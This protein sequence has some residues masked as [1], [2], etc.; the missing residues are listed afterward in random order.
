M[1][2]DLILI[3]NQNKGFSVTL[4]EAKGSLPP[5]LNLVNIYDNWKSSLKK[6]EKFKTERQ[7]TVLRNSKVSPRKRMRERRNDYNQK[8]RKTKEAYGEAEEKLINE[9]NNWLRAESF[10]PIVEEL[11]K[12]SEDTQKILQIRLITSDLEITKLPWHNWSWI[13]ERQNRVSIVFRPPLEKY[14]YP[15]LIANYQVKAL[16]VLGN[17][18]DS[19]EEK[20]YNDS[21]INILNNYFKNVDVHYI[22]NPSTPKIYEKLKQKYDIIYIGFHSETK[23]NK[24]QFQINQTD[25][26]SIDNL[27]CLLEKQNNVKLLILN[28]CDGSGAS[29]LFQYNNKFKIGNLIYHRNFLHHKS[30][31]IFLKQLLIS[32]VQQNKSLDIAVQDAI[33]YLDNNNTTDNLNPIKQECP[34]ANLTP[35]YIQLSQKSQY[36]KNW[37]SPFPSFP[38]SRLITV[39]SLLV[40][41]FVMGIK[42]LGFFEPLGLWAFDQLMR[43]KPNEEPDKRILVVQA[44][45]DD[46]KNQKIKPESKDTLLGERRQPSLSDDTLKQLLEKLNKYEPTAIGLDIDRDFYATSELKTELQKDHVFGVCKKTFLSGSGTKP[47]PEINNIGFVDAIEDNDKTL[48]RHILTSSPENSDCPVNANLSF[49]LGLYYLYKQEPKLY[50]LY[51][52]KQDEIRNKNKNAC[53][54]T[55]GKAELK[56]LNFIS[57]TTNNP[58]FITRLFQN[59]QGSY[60]NEDLRGCQ[61]MLNYRI[62]DSSIK[63]IAE[64]VTLGQVLNDEISEEKIKYSLILVG[65]VD[66]PKESNDYWRTPYSREEIAG[67]FIQAQMLSQILSAALDGRS[68]INPLLF[69]QDL[70]V[71]FACSFISSLTVY[72][73]TDRLGKPKTFLVICGNGFLICV[74]SFCLLL[75]LGIWLPLIPSV[76]VII[77]APITIWIGEIDFKR[78]EKRLNKLSI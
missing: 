59:N 30:S 69:W 17:L 72:L 58:S 62:V 60:H 31:E 3:S 50:E 33:N 37:F 63:N 24:F 14:P 2:I 70:I 43:L 64:T 52:N 49:L 54:F 8:L 5:F 34:G 19:E 51:Q 74:I 20:K 71:I 11:T 41:L 78:L 47:S 22:V 67:V 56:A 9:F 57:K 32:F 28:C 65:I 25:V 16:V 26:L 42:S 61:I 18:L 53:I 66:S 75:K 35:V 23:E 15:K 77:I 6:L 29:E 76:L 40:T 36:W 39:Y 4:K 45:P 10:Q 12:I 48:R 68:L 44:T 21:I 38:E 27:N 13:L 73:L 55:L 46:I 1:Q 7:K